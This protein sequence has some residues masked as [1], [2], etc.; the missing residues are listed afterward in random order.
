MSGLTH[1]SIFW[2]NATPNNWLTEDWSIRIVGILV[3]FFSLHANHIFALHG[4]EHSFQKIKASLQ[5]CKTIEWKCQRK[6]ALYIIF[7]RRLCRC[8]CLARDRRCSPWPAWGRWWRLLSWQALRETVWWRPPVMRVF[9]P[10]I[11]MV[12][13]RCEGSMAGG[14]VIMKTQNWTQ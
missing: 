10:D 6:V 8:P 2:V 5:K 14:K 11:Q 7:L 9:M 4:N 13:G 12:K 3:S 1:V